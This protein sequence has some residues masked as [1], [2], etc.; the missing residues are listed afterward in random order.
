MAATGWISWGRGSSI[1]GEDAA[2]LEFGA[3]EGAYEFGELGKR[4]ATFE[5]FFELFELCAHGDALR[6]QKAEMDDAA[7]GEKL[8]VVERELD[9]HAL[10]DQHFGRGTVATGPADGAGAQNADVLQARGDF[11][12][13]HGAT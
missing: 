12:R 3:L 9:A 8:L 7:F 2:A 4:L 5:I 6:V 1:G 11:L 10:A 13:R